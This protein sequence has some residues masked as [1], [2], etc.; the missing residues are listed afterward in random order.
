MVQAA[1][2]HAME[3]T[4]GQRELHDEH[5]GRSGGTSSMH[6]IGPTGRSHLQH[7]QAAAE[8]RGEYIFAKPDHLGIQ[9]GR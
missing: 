5:E 2:D 3:A 7:A 1:I 4:R 6:D 8:L 9:V